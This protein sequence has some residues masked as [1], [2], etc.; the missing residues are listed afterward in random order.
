MPAAQ[1]GPV[2][3]GGPGTAPA[4][5]TWAVPAAFDEWRT[6]REI[7][8]SYDPPRVFSNT[9]LDTLLP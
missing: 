7:L 5:L 4:V 2:T 3:D 9:F 8:N 1:D 6:V